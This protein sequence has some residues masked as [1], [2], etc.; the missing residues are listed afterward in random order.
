MLFHLTGTEAAEEAIV[1]Q[2]TTQYRPINYLT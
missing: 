1:K 2:L